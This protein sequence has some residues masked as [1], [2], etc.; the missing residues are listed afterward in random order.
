MKISETLKVLSIKITTLNLNAVMMKMKE[1]FLELLK[2]SM[3][4]W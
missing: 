2:S 4:T 3:E 1:K